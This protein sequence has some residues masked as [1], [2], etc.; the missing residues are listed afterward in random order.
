MDAFRADRAQLRRATVFSKE[1]WDVA[2][3][4]GRSE[5]ILLSA[6]RRSRPVRRDFCRQFLSY[7]GWNAH[8]VAIHPGYAERLLPWALAPVVGTLGSGG[9]GPWFGSSGLDCALKDYSKLNGFQRLWQE[10][11]GAKLNGFRV[12]MD[13]IQLRDKD[14]SGI[15]PHLLHFRKQVQADLGHRQ[16]DQ[17]DVRRGGKNTKVS[18]SWVEA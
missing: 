9:H 7:R 8:F 5:T 17:N 2:V 6:D 4:M 16:V 3:K 1:V 15:R 10:I 13:I 11:I 18:R 14:H 12:K